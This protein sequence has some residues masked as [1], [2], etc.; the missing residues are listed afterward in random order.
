MGTVSGNV[1]IDLA[2]TSIANEDVS[3]PVDSGR[4]YRVDEFNV[5]AWPNGD[6]DAGLILLALGSI[7][8]NQRTSGL[9]SQIYQDDIIFRWARWFSSISNATVGS[10]SAYNEFLNPVN[11]IEPVGNYFNGDDLRILFKIQSLADGGNT[12]NLYYQLR[13]E[14]VRLTNAIRDEMIARRYHPTS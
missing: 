8:I 6:G 12:W 13:Y 2:S 4:V 5:T 7:A 3:L 14:S 1:T 11:Q 9:L 10:S